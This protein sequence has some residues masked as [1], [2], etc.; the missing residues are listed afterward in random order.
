MRVVN[1]IMRVAVLT[2]ALSGCTMTPKTTL[3]ADDS[4]R[5]SFPANS[6][7]KGKNVNPVGTLK[8]PENVEDKVPLVILVHGTGGVG[9]RESTWSSFL[10]DHGIATFILDYFAPRNVKPRDREIPQ[11]PQD[12]WGALKVLA[13]HP[14][15]DNDRVAIMGFSNGATITLISNG[16]ISTSDTGGIEPKAYF[17]LYGGCARDSIGNNA[18]DA[19][20]RFLVGSEDTLISVANCKRQQ[21]NGQKLGKDVQT[22]VFSCVHHGFDGNRSHNFNHAKW[23]WVVMK[24]DQSATESA[25]AEVIETLIQVFGADRVRL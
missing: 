24:P 7:W 17:M 16:Y 20:Y 22:L 23:G 18:P 12:V 4:G 25:R 3:T 10:R 19:S 15:I 5:F 6:Y 13:T 2:V 9:Y 21:T 8:F 14:R 1:W 11:P